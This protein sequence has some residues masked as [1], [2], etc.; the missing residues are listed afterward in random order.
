M[1]DR[2]RLTLAQAGAVVATLELTEVE[3]DRAT[4]GYLRVEVGGRVRWP[5]VRGGLAEFVR[6][7]EADGVAGFHQDGLQLVLLWTGTQCLFA[8]DPEVRTSWPIS[9]DADGLRE[10]FTAV[11]SLDEETL[12]R[13]LAWCV[14][15]E[16]AVIPSW[17]RSP[18]EQAALS[19]WSRRF[20]S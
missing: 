13:V 11:L 3:Q 4:E 5:T 17:Q 19:A 16:G 9:R 10:R 6:R 14:R 18:E 20:S 12:Q 2:D 7:F 8:V 1:T 15:V